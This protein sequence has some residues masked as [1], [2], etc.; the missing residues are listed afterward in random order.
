MVSSGYHRLLSISFFS[1]IVLNSAKA[2]CVDRNLTDRCY[3]PSHNNPQNLQPV[4][5][6]ALHSVPS[7]SHNNPRNLQPVPSPALHSVPSQTPS[8]HAVPP[9]SNPS[10]PAV[11]LVSKLVP[12]QTPSPHAVPPSF[13]NPSPHAVPPSFSNPSP[14]AVPSVSKSVPSQTPPSHAFPSSF[15]NP[16]PHAVPSVLNRV[17]DSVPRDSVHVA[18][19]L[20]ITDEAIMNIC[21]STDYPLLCLSSIKPYV[22]GR[23]DP[24]SVLEM[25]IKAS[26]EH[27]KLA[28][29]ALE[30]LATT[31]RCPAPRSALDCCKDSYDDALENIYTAL[32]AVPAR[33][34]GTVNTMLSAAITDLGDCE[35]EYSGMSS[36]L[37]IAAQ[38][39]DNMVSNCLAIVSLI[40]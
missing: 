30:R 27:T 3:F 8:S 4:P 15:S 22:N 11:P 35:D 38:K 39:L 10:P 12:S 16:S 36:L 34:I 26:V 25:A 28:L 19:L 14:H 32:D 1:L 24:L 9:F 6:P 40:K 21:H 31:S 18:S 37:P 20:P 5:S 7:Q 33:D 13:S 29:S 2:Y 23:N 17:S